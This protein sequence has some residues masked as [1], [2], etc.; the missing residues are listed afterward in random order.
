LRTHWVKVP[1]ATTTEA[2]RP[3]EPGADYLAFANRLRE[4]TAAKSA[5]A[6]LG[7]PWCPSRSVR[8]GNASSNID[9]FIRGQQPLLGVAGAGAVAAPFALNALRQ[10]PAPQQ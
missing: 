2:T 1:T 5:Q 9:A 10:P 3:I 8:A 4:I 6:R 7:Q